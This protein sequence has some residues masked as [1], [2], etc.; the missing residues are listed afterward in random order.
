MSAPAT[1]RQVSY[2][3]SLLDDRVFDTDKRNEAL[4]KIR[5]GDMD[6]TTASSLIDSLLR[7]PK[8]RAAAA[9]APR[10]ELEEGGMYMHDGTVYHIRRSNAGHLYAVKLV[11]RKFEFVRGMMNVLTPEHQ[12]TL[13]QAKAYGVQYGVCCV[14]GRTLTNEVSVAEGI[15]PICAGR[16]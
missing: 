3:T 2:L 4:A 12:L 9:A 1:E 10:V 16:F 7:A 13:E 14:C 6:K 15:G 8:V 11:G 5:L